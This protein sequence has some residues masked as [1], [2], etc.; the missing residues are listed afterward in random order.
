MRGVVHS[1]S[2][3]GVFGKAHCCTSICVEKGT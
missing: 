1:V 2:L 3:L